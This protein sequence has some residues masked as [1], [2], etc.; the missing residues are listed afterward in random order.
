MAEVIKHGLIGDRH[1]FERCAHGWEALEGSSGRIDGEELVRQVAAVKIK[2][3]L[4]DPY[5]QGER[6]VLNLGH[7]V[8]H[9]VERSSGYRLSHGEAVA[10]G[11]VVEARL[12]EAIGLAEKGLAETI[13]RA[14]SAFGLPVRIPADLEEEPIRQGLRVDKKRRTGRA[15]LALA[16]R[17]GVARYG[18]EVDEEEIWSQCW[19]CMD[20]T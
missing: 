18:V 5:E 1:L 11:L 6:E 2:V 20:R 14:L 17:V 7:T 10:I 3:L 12:A 16:A 9:A 4:R 8:G 13:E 15:R 19:S